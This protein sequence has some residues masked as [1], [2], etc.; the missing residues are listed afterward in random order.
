MT[1]IIT[2]VLGLYNL[3][4]AII[5]FSFYL[6]QG[7]YSASLTTLQDLAYHIKMTININ[8]ILLEDNQ[9]FGHVLF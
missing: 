7:F 5:L 8:D 4:P 9:G 2:T 3:D 6:W 1:D